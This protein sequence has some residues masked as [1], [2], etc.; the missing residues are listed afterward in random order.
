MSKQ[1]RPAL[2]VFGIC[3][4]MAPCRSSGAVMRSCRNAAQVAVAFV[5]RLGAPQPRRGGPVQPRAGLFLSVSFKWRRKR[6]IAAML[7]LTFRPASRCRSSLS[8]M[9]GCSAI[10]CVSRSA[11][12]SQ[13]A[14]PTQQ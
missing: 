9:S 12:G 7:T 1:N 11:C 8:V 14:F 13:L 2:I 3:P 6:K 10:Q 4:F 5:A